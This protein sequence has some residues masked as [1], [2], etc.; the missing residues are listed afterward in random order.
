MTAKVHPAD[1]LSAIEA[2]LGAAKV[3]LPPDLQGALDSLGAEVGPGDPERLKAS[4]Q[5]LLPELQAFQAE[6]RAAR[7]DDTIPAVRRALDVEAIQR[8]VTGQLAAAWGQQDGE[9][10]DAAL[11]RPSCAHRRPRR[12]SARAWS[13]KPR[14]RS[15]RASPG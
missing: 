4:L 12:P 13:L 11:A 2:L 9:G 14:R 15:R 5:D 3:T 8:Q 6:A 10:V 1:V 7:L